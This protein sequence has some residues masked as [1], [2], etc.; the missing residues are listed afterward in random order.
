VAVAKQG[1]D[2]T[3]FVSGPV[4]VSILLALCAVVLLF[5]LGSYGLVSGDE[6]FYHGVAESMVETGN[7]FSIDFRGQHRP[8]D[9]FMNAPLQ[10]W[11]RAGLIELFGSNYWTMRIASASFGIACVLLVYRMLLP[12]AGIRAAFLAGCVQLTTY[13]FVYLHS[14]RSGV[15]ETTLAFLFALTAHLFLG[16]I[17]GRR[18][19]IAH[20]LCIAALVNLKL[21]TAIIPLLAELVYFAIDRDA[22]R[23]AG[24][25][26]VTGIAI[27]P[28]ALAWHLVQAFAL[29]EP[30]LAVLQRMA[31]QGASQQDFWSA[32]SGNLLFYAG[33]L[34][35]GTMPYALLYPWAIWRTL[36]DAGAQR[37]DATACW[38]LYALFAAAVA[39]FFVTI[40]KNSDWYMIPALPFLSA[41]V[42]VRL[43][44]AWQN[45]LGRGAWLGLAGLATLL[46]WLDVD[47]SANP[48]DPFAPATRAAI[49]WNSFGVVEPWW[50]IPLTFAA[51][52][53]CLAWLPA[54]SGR[55]LPVLLLL[56]SAGF[57]GV[58]VALPLAHTGYMSSTESIWRDLSTARMMDFAVDY[59]V[60]IPQGSAISA[61]TRFY[62]ARDFDIVPRVSTLPGAAVGYL[63]YPKGQAPVPDDGSPEDAAKPREPDR[64]EQPDD[65]GP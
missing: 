2:D 19:F 32:S 15:V 17:R 48:F 65:V 14:A 12:I 60:E 33:T 16:A 45:G 39:G 56:C 35:Y 36:R 4:A 3:G 63:L 50:G 30:I 46:I 13:Q 64:V 37:G 62:F 29:D 11:L 9:T 18:G 23:V 47:L 8:Y 55:T 61:K 49:R 43:A 24:R 5:R 53:G 20:H 44:G 57:A 52:A 22:R 34:L 38:R 7:W 31:I 51:F 58:R 42:G 26:L 59:P 40:G 41:F 28:L 54:R 27:A 10:Y 6:A 25:W 1:P 21:P